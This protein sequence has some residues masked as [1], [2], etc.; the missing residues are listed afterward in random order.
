MKRIVFAVLISS[1]ALLCQGQQTASFAQYMFNP[2]AINP[3]YAG[4]HNLLSASAITRFQNVGLEGAPRT[5]TFSIHSPL[6]DKSISGGALFIRD[7]IG[8]I[9]QTGLHGIGAYRIFF[10]EKGLHSLSFGIQFGMI[11]YRANYANLNSFQPNDPYFSNNVQQSRPNLGFGMFYR[12]ENY[13]LGIA[14][15][16]LMNNVFDR[17]SDFTTVNQ[18]VP[19]L[20]HGGYVFTLNP[21]LKFKPNF[22]FKLLDGRAKEIDL[23]ASFQLDELLWIGASYKFPG[24]NLL[25]EFRLTEQLLFGYSYSLEKGELRDVGIG[26]HEILLNFRFKFTKYR[27]V[28]P[29]YF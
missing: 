4:S 18:A 22:L 26:T 16:H 5:Q 2:L 27:L 25:T 11:G 10:D 3:A 1:I 15:P 7:Q 29:R 17:G 20:V 23:N 12:N 9:S 21:L 13:F 19:F 8:I 24:I 6:W 14:M 28:S